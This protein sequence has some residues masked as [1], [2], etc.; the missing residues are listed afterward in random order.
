[1]PADK[2]IALGLAP[3]ILGDLIKIGVV[4]AGC[5]VVPSALARL[6]GLGE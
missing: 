1:V 4:A 2:L 5:A 6:R 3:F